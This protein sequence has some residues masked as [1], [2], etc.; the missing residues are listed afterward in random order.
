LEFYDSISPFTKL[1]LRKKFHILVMEIS[2]SLNP[3]FFKDNIRK[4][5]MLKTLEKD[6][7]IEIISS[8]G[9]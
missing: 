9:S 5:E 6:E 7:F 8:I 4:I 1:K 3:S 2:S